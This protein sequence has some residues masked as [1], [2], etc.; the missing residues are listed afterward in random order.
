MTKTLKSLF[1][2][3]VATSTKNDKDFLSPQHTVQKHRDRNGNGDDVFTGSKVKTTKRAPEHG[4]DADDD[5]KAHISKNSVPKEQGHVREEVDLSEG[6]MNLSKVHQVW[7]SDDKDAK[8]FAKHYVAAM[9]GDHRETGPTDKDERAADD[10]Y[11]RYDYKHTRHGFAG[12]GTT[13]YKDKETGHHWKV[14]RSPNG[15]TFY[16]TDHVI[17]KVN[18]LEEEAEQI[19]EATAK[20][21]YWVTDHM[22]KL[23]HDKPFRDSKE[24][25]RHADREED[26]T[27]RVHTVSHVKGGKIKKQWQYQSHTGDASGWFPHT[28]YKDEDFYHA[29]LKEEV[30][31]IDELSKDTMMSYRDKTAEERAALSR[32]RTRA[33]TQWRNRVR[34]GKGLSGYKPK[35]ALTDD[36]KRKLKNRMDGESRTRNKMNQF[37][38]N[39]AVEQI[40]E[41]SKS[42]VRSYLNKS[43]KDLDDTLLTKAGTPRPKIS[44]EDS[45]RV[46]KRLKGGAMASKRLYT[47]ED[48]DVVESAFNR[49]VAGRTDAAPRKNKLEE[50]LSVVAPKT[51]D[52]IMSIYETL[53]VENQDV[54]LD[55]SESI[56]GINELVD[57]VI[58]N[59]EF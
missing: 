14:N 48:T 24:A 57:F 26:R 49:Y 11:N 37:M 40:D 56:E 1:E 18:S 55:L 23:T 10:F 51:R 58:T 6:K 21:G 7:H 13:I 32:K 30:E 19:D 53:S 41:L 17:N 47:A 28:D 20:D 22:S 43:D 44:D 25:I 50:N 54:M 29:G 39:E 45:H 27:A 12:S 34:S 46:S 16:G 35:D 38:K 36:E 5:V 59:G 31:Q 42:S 33:E 4:Y 3:Y 52:A 2:L 9:K 8:T 15:K